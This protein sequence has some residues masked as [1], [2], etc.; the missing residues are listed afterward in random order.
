M[1]PLSRAALRA[2]GLAAIAALTLAGCGSSGDGDTEPRAAASETTSQ[3]SD[4][5]SDE[6]SATEQT[7]TA[8][9]TQTVEVTKFGISFQ[10]PEGWITLDAKKALEG[11]GQ[12]AFLEEMADKLGTTQDQLVKSFSTIVQTLSV[13]DEGAVHGFLT[14]VNTVGQE[15]ELNDDQ[16]KLQLASIGAKP[17]PIDHATSEA[18]DVTRVPYDLA[19]KAMTVRAVALAVH[20]DAGTVVVT[21]SSSTSAEAGRIADQIQASLRKIPGTGPGA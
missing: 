1:T 15:A 6:P 9:D 3:P 19:A 17:G 5:P 16:I 8:T 2:V 18:G 14:N 13:S 10:L 7:S 12:N 4:G 20:A 21:V 11:G